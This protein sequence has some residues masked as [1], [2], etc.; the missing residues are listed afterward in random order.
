MT[1][2]R[3]ETPFD[4]DVA[5]SAVRAAVAPFPKAAMFAL[6]EQGFRTPFQQ[7]VACIISIRTRDEESLP[8]SLRLFGT[9]GTPAAVAALPV[10]AIDALIR[11][12]TFHERKADQIRAL[13]RRVV[14]EFDGELPCDETVM[15]SFA[16]V[17]E[18]CA[19]LA[20]GIACG[21]A[22]IS[23]DVHVHRIVNRW[24]YVRTSTPERTTAALEETLPSHHW[25]EINALLV[26][27]GK[28]VCTG[29]APKC[30]RCPVL[31]MCRQVGVT[32]HR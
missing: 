6:A 26:P 8:L 10:E 19:N 5:L 9:A 20:L 28:H 24:G 2:A 15:R 16:G 22:K 21:Q 18:K 17:G 1:A 30:S 25:V 13:A 4:I 3:T 27:F 23:V 32:V 7:L 31:K 11:T 12:S 29:I 14:D